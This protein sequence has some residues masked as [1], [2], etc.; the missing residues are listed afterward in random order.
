MFKCVRPFIGHRPMT[1]FSKLRSS[2]A[3]ASYV[4][5]RLRALRASVPYAPYVPYPRTLSTRL[6]RLFY[7]LF[8]RLKISLGWICSPAETSHFPRIIKG[9][10]NSVVL[11]CVKNSRETF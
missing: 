6:A 9:T 5:L 10:A 2:R 3:F 4:H 1:E 7:A 11:V 8:V